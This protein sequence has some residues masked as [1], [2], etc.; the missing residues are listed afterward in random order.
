MSTLVVTH[1]EYKALAHSVTKK[2]SVKQCNVYYSYR[3]SHH[4]WASFTRRNSHTTSKTSNQC[5]CKTHNNNL[6][7]ETSFIF[8]L[9]VTHKMFLI[10]YV[11]FVTLYISSYMFYIT[12]CTIVPCHN[13]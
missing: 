13:I 6:L 5:L 10:V 1:S 7:Q 9:K 2:T 11:C 12:M 8:H 3:Y 4:C